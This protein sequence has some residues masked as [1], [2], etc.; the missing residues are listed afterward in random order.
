MK[1]I[2]LIKIYIQKKIFQNLK[3]FK[4]EI[5]KIKFEKKNNMKI[6]DEFLTKK[7]NE[8]NLNNINNKKNDYNIYNFNEN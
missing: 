1:I 5:E 6:R 2:L 3:E 7:L 4:L 8:E